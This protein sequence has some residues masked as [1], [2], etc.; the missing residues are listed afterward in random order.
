VVTEISRD[1]TLSG[2]DVDWL[3][4][5]LDET[6]VPIVA[7][8]GVSALDDI[9]LLRSLGAAG[10]I[11]GKAIYEGRFNIEEAVLACGR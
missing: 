2:P 4:R 11:V 9:D 6:T 5:L 10:A 7:S 8:G 3:S 1:A